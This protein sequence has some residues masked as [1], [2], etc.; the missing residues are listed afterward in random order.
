[1]HLDELYLHF[2]EKFR[3]LPNPR[4]VAEAAITAGEVAVLTQWFSVGWEHRTWCEST[5]RVSD[6]ISASRQEMFGALMLILASEV[7]RDRSNEDAVW[8]AVTAIFK[9]NEVSFPALFVGGQPSPLCKRAIGAGARK[10]HLRNLVDRYGAQEY[11][12]TLKLQFG[13]TLNGAR[14]RLP[15]WL[16]GAGIPI[17]VKIL[18]GDEPVYLDLRSRSFSE[19]WKTLQNFRR[20]RIEE[21]QA[22]MILRLSPWIRPHWAPTLLESARLRPNRA[23]SSSSVTSSGCSNEPEYELVLRWDN[24]SSPRLVLRINDDERIRQA[25]AGQDSATFTIDRQF[26]GRWVAET[27]GGW[28]GPRELPCERQGAKPN[29]RPKSLSITGEGKLIEEVDLFEAFTIGEPLLVFDPKTGARIELQSKLDPSR[30]YALMCDV[31]LSLGLA[32][33]TS[34]LKLKDRLLYRIVGPWN[35][36]LAVLS[37]GVLYWKPKVAEGERV[38]AI[39][40]VLESLPGEVATIGSTCHIRVSGVPG[41]VTAVSLSIGNS[42]HVVVHIGEVWQTIEPVKITLGT[43]LADERVRVR[44]T[45][46]EYC[47]MV[48]PKLALNLRGIACVETGSEDLEPHWKLLNPNLPIDRADGAGSAR[49]FF[50]ARRSQLYEGPTLVG[51]LSTRV[52]RLGDLHGWGEPLI[53]RGEDQTGEVLVNSVE[54]RGSLGLYVGTLLGK[55]RNEIYLRLPIPCGA[56]HCVFVWSDLAHEPRIVVGKFVVSNS[57]GFVWKL[58]E[59]GLVAAMAVSFRGAWIG[60]YWVA[61]PLIRA[62]RNEPSGK[63]FALA[64]WLKLP[65][66]N[67]IFKPTMQELIRRMPTEF[68][69]AW[70]S[71]DFL[72]PGLQHRQAEQGLEAVVRAFF[73]THVESNEAG[74]DRLARAFLGSS[75]GEIESQGES[76]VF[77]SSIHRLGEICPSLAYNLARHKLRGDKYRKYV[78]TVV[79]SLLR[80]SETVDLRELERYLIEDRRYC[81]NL[82]GITPEALEGSAN[83][84]GCRL[85]GKAA[86][87]TDKDY[88]LSRLGERSR[89]RQF[90]TAVLLF[91]L[92]KGS[93]F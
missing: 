31:D 5:F 51:S 50:G 83:A 65:V 8:P 9:A 91:R 80:Q 92:L 30:D 10:L 12:D 81:A 17:A 42:T 55:A 3:E 67:P 59:L 63:L 22:I 48:L 93:S 72:P 34:A 32:D 11:F 7:C 62:L 35:P 49:I 6:R 46:R 25:L 44:L 20:G 14:R 85:D 78:R 41:D 74:M 54:D 28:R 90:I 21:E 26:V 66:L 37:N 45:T 58:P 86:G 52:L 1:M 57:D 24:A 2:S 47:R 71:S 43:A 4:S 70:L 38:P 23:S 69:S 84:L 77:K 56:D 88:D 76:A 87:A 13:F 89:G 39:R 29:L 73:W 60:S 16:D 18:I 19:L 79:G 75:R 36:N 64:R 68:I 40:V 15:D 61:D 33:G 53:A 27:A 82:V